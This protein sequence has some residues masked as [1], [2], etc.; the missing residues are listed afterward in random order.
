LTAAD[1]D[2]IEEIRAKIVASASPLDLKKAEG[3]IVEIEFATRM[4]QILYASETPRVKRSDVA[5]ALKALREAH[6]LDADSEH[7]LHDAYV[8]FRR[9]ENRIR[10]ML[11]RS[12]SALPDSEQ[13]RA[14][15]A[16]R[17]AIDGDLN[18]I[19]QDLKTRVHGVYLD[20]LHACRNA[21]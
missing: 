16:G 6:A 8:L 13:A 10:M 4:L 19:V 7:T 15:L 20:T 1:L 5:G 3:G 11:G 14:D 12:A 18:E 17:L 21:T 9:I 2:H